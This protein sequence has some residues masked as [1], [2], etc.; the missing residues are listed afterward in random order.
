MEEQQ[1]SF[2]RVVHLMAAVSVC[3]RQA[4]LYSGVRGR[5]EETNACTTPCGKF[6]ASP[7]LCSAPCPHKQGCRTLAF[8][9]PNGEPYESRPF[10][11]LYHTMREISGLA[12]LVLRTV[13]A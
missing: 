4:R 1:F 12:G 9:P 5:P 11:R 7:G 3:P 2:R 8:P 6:P 13:S 10:E